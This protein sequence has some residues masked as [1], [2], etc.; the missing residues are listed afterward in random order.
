MPDSRT[1]F[2][3][4]DRNGARGL[5]RQELDSREPQPLLTAAEDARG[6]RLSP[7]GRWILYLSWP[8]GS[9][10]APAGQGRLMRVA[11]TGGPKETLFAVGGFAIARAAGYPALEPRHPRFRCPSAGQATC[12]VSERVDN[13]VVFTAFDPVQGRKGQLASPDLEGAGLWDLSPDGRWIA[14]EG[15]RRIRLVPLA[16]QAPREILMENVIGIENILEALAWAADGQSLFV[17][18]RTSQGEPLLRVLLD[19]KTQ[20][21]YRGTKYLHSPVASPDGRYVAFTDLKVES[22]AWV[23]ENLR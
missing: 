11:T 8:T 14:V 16:G 20:L 9:H 19:G 4:S 5:F 10:D 1:L 6:A 3:D 12:V 13:Q 15:Q 2:F 18:P 7:D 21:L 23:I 22:N 17:V